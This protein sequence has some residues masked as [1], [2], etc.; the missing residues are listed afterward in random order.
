[1]LDRSIHYSMASSQTNLP[2]HKEP[3]ATGKSDPEK[4]NK[5]RKAQHVAPPPETAESKPTATT[6]LLA[7]TE[8]SAKDD[9][10]GRHSENS[11]ENQSPLS[12][13]DSGDDEEGQKSQ[14]QKSFGMLQAK[15]DEMFTRLVTFSE[16]HGHCLVPNR[17][18]EDP[19]LGSWGTC[20]SMR[21]WRGALTALNATVPSST[22]Y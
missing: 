12:A 2:L 13:E 3:K 19:Q 11:T 22:V 15:W 14:A 8:G 10:S 17:Y 1:M 5:K 9:D 20:V 21:V 16:K 4:G 6:S 7:K 18:T